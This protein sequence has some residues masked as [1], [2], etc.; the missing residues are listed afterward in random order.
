MT[1]RVGGAEWLRG[2]CCSGSRGLLK[3]PRTTAVSQSPSKH[4]RHSR[5]RLYTA[6][7]LNPRCVRRLLVLEN[8]RSPSQ[9]H[10]AG[11]DPTEVFGAAL[12]RRRK[13]QQTSK[14]GAAEAAVSGLLW[15][16]RGAGPSC[17]SSGCVSSGSPLVNPCVAP[18][19]T[20]AAAR[21]GREERP[22]QK[23]HQRE[24]WC[25]QVILVDK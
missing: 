3:V 4:P 18:S 22:E 2:P 25:Y 20:T 14:Q 13:E 1:R 23:K 24:D 21:G 8:K 17:W 12:T 7:K 15:W 6:A 9:R 19:Q 5:R 11:S 16:L 10:R